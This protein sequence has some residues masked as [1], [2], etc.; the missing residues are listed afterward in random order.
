MNSKIILILIIAF[1]LITLLLAI[2]INWNE[3]NEYDEMYPNPSRMGACPPSR[4]Y[5]YETM[6]MTL[7]GILSMNFMLLY[8]A[9][10]IV[11]KK[12]KV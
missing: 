10:R 7:F 8:I 5:M 3:V 12:E 1:T 4:P 6:L 9:L 2:S 11:E